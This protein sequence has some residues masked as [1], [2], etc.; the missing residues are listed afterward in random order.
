MRQVNIYEAKTQ[1]SRL[2]AAVERGEEVVI[3][4]AG[5]PVVKLVS[6]SPGLR[7]AGWA[8]DLID[9]SEDWD[10]PETN[11]AVADLLAGDSGDE[12]SP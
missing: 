9:A 6:L 12:A 5:R 7:A 3:A 4:R 8:R 1:L 2:V 11:E 10:S